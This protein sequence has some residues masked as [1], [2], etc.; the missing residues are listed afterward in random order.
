MILLFVAS[1]ESGLQKLVFYSRT[2][3]LINLYE[4]ADFMENTHSSYEIVT[5]KMETIS[6][7]ITCNEITEA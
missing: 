2:V 3:M 4:A 5:R 6:L 1:L 7:R